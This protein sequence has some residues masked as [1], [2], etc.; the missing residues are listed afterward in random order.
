MILC[1]IEKIACPVTLKDAQIAASDFDRQ[2]LQDLTKSHMDVILNRMLSMKL[3]TQ[4]T[5]LAV[6]DALVEPTQP[7]KNACILKYISDR[8]GAPIRAS[9]KSV[10]LSNFLNLTSGICV[11]VEYQV[12]KCDDR[13]GTFWKHAR[14]GKICRYQTIG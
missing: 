10:T 7:K 9:I 1:I 8:A 5:V 6:A 12:H 14:S 3:Q 4:K 11:E 13:Q 2:G